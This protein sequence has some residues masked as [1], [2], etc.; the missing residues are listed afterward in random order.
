[1]S[2]YVLRISLQT[3]DRYRGWG[4]RTTHAYVHISTKRLVYGAGVDDIYVSATWY[5]PIGGYS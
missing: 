1:M 2:Q 4:V 5:E 3:R